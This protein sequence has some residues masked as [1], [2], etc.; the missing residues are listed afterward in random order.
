MAP[1]TFY[2]AVMPLRLRDAVIRVECARGVTHSS[3]HPSIHPCDGVTVMQ[4]Q[5]SINL[6]LA[7]VVI[8]FYWGRIAHRRLSTRQAL[9]FTAPFLPDVQLRVGKLPI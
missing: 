9:D 4:F 3:I 5:V 2:R 8:A 7:R 6:A 1:N